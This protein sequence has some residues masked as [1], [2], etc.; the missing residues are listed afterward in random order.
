MPVQTPPVML[1]SMAHEPAQDSRPEEFAGPA[2]W[3]PDLVHVRGHTLAVITGTSGFRPASTRRRAAE[4][5]RELLDELAEQGVTAI[6]SAS[7]SVVSVDDSGVCVE[8][9][10]VASERVRTT[11]SIRVTERP[12]HHAAT[13]L[14][15]G[16]QTDRA[17]GRLRSFLVDVCAEANGRSYVTFQHPRGDD[18]RT[19]VTQ[20]VQPIAPPGA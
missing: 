3:A 14:V 7:M 20:L 4:L 19:W 12:A 6:G 11:A 9:G 13:L 15:H 10:V 2:A 8:V 5:L 1:A 18:E 17:W 16:D